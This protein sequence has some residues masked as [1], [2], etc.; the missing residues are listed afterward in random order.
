[1]V[2]LEI[3]NKGFV[4][5]GDINLVDL[6]LDKLEILKIDLDK[7]PLN[8]FIVCPMLHTVYINNRINCIDQFKI[9]NPLS[10]R[11]LTCNTTNS[12]KK[13]KNLTQLT[14]L[15]FDYTNYTGKLLNDL[16]GL[17]KI[18]IRFTTRESLDRLRNEVVDMRMSRNVLVYYKNC[19][20]QSKHFNF[21]LFFELSADRLNQNQL[22]LHLDCLNNLN[23]ILSQKSLYNVDLEKAPVELLAKLVYLNEI[24][25]SNHFVEI[26]KWM[27]LLTMFRLETLKLKIPMSDQF[28]NQIPICQSTLRSLKMARCND[29]E[30]V[31]RLPFL[32][33]LKTKEFMG[34]DLF[35]Q[36]MERL[37][38]LETVAV[39]K[40]FV[41]DLTD[42]TIRCK[43]GSIV[44]YQESKAIFMSISIRLV[45]KL[46]DLFRPRIPYVNSNYCTCNYHS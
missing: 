11:D 45:S 39:L 10:V 2:H 23:D 30:F 21:D 46:I 12:L 14:Y 31:L 8:F 3:V 7:K 16:I 4:K 29:M 32:K 41:F 18:E 24:N 20:I 43:H 22:D 44:T 33:V 38:Y 13:F 25:V 17:K 28:L 42:D 15:D 19:E 34:V 40:Y 27:Q 35:K 6:N 9:Y 5:N 36:M 1:M 37:K 26:R